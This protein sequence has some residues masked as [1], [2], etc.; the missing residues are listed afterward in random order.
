MI[1]QNRAAL[2]LMDEG[3][4]PETNAINEWVETDNDEGMEGL[5]EEASGENIPLASTD[6]DPNELRS[7]IRH[8]IEIL[9]RWRD[10]AKTV[11]RDDDEKLHALR[12]TL[13]DIV[14]TAKDHAEATNL[15]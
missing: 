1:S 3:Y 7:D 6:V 15:G 9:E 12:E 2:Q 14:E 11:S 8:D 10:G 4:F 5:L 13:K